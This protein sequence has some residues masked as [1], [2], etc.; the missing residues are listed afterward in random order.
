MDNALIRALVC[1]ALLWSVTV[2]AE[3]GRPDAAARSRTVL[4]LGDSLIV[5]SFGESLEQLLNAQPGLRA[6][7]RAKSSTGLARPDFFDWMKVGREEVERHQPDVVVVI[8][9][10]N[11]GQGLTDEQGKAKVQW[12]VSGW[13]AAYQ[14]RATEFLR[15]LSAPGRK[16]L[17]VELPFTGLPR[18]ERKLE[19]IRRVL[20]EAVRSDSASTH[21]ET[22]PFFV[23][24]RGH[25]LREAPVEGFRKPMRL[26]MADGVHFTVAGGRYFAN[27]VH[28]V[29]MSLLEAPPEQA[30]AP[31]GTGSR[32]AGSTSLVPSPLVRGTP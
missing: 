17:W 21:L 19:I 24:A 30:V 31:I 12:G 27:K 20:R 23:D 16:V 29:V 2:R 7:R 15:T 22:R 26:R 9:G 5:T 4:L 1:L 8:L 10:G 28:P 25:L 18:F 6:V 32:E 3:E 14:Q 13:E 11:D